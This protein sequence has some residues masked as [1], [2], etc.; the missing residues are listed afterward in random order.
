MNGSVNFLLKFAFTVLLLGSPLM[1]DLGRAAAGAVDPICGTWRFWNNSV[2][3]MRS[4]GS[5][6]PATCS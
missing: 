1:V 6:G 3:E 4:D 5:S 2:R